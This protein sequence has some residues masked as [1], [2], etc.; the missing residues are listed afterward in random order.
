MMNGEPRA[1]STGEG[2]PLFTAPLKPPY[3]RILEVCRPFL[4]AYRGNIPY[5]D[6]APFGLA[7]EPEL[8]FDPTTVR[9]LSFIDG[10]HALD[11]A[12]FGA[13]G[14][15]MPRWVL[16][17]CG[18][19]PGIV[20]GFARRAGAL[21][22]RARELYGA[23]PEAMVPLSMWIAIPCAEPGTWV[24]HNLASAN[25]VLEGEALPG[26]AKLTK[27]LGLRVVR[28]KKQVGVTQWTSSSVGI[29]L[30]F[31]DLGL[32]SAWTPAHTFPETFSYC[33]DVDEGRL[34]GSLTQGYEPPNARVDQVINPEDAGA[35]ME[36]QAE[37]EAGAEVAIV[38]LE[39]ATGASPGRAHLRRGRG[40]AGV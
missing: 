20:F 9:S 31:G 18:E 37:I 32:L 11:S 14:M 28:A 15:P 2:G 4:V 16:F 13:V 17:D 35:L 29:H 34:L 3:R 36:L 26:L 10:L 6:R 21:P 7:I 25:T 40:G 22:P 23:P 27:A 5:L 38:R 12:T 19:L 30:S 24:G 39:P 33:I 1:D 8:C